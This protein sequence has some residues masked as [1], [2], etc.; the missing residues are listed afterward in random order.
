MESLPRNFLAFVAAAAGLVLSQVATTQPA[1]SQSATTPTKAFP[2]R[3]KIE[4]VDP[5]SDEFK[6]T[7]ALLKEVRGLEG[8]QE[9]LSPIVLP[10]DLTLRAKE[11]GMVNAWYNREDGKP[12]VTICYD[13]VADYIKKLPKDSTPEGITRQ[14]AAAGQF[15]WLVT[16]ESG[17]AMFDIFRMPIMGHEENAAD[18]FATYMMLH[19]GK[20]RARRLIGGSAWSYHAYV[21]DDRSKRLTKM[22]TIGFASAHAQPE[23]RFYNQLCLAYGADPVTFADL[24]KDDWLPESRAKTCRDDFQTL[25]FA[26][27]TLITPHVD[28]DLAKPIHD[29][30]W[31]PVNTSAPQ[32]TKAAT[33]AAKP[34]K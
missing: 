23:E 4:Y 12:V 8:M 11:C 1:L 29:I 18:N 21:S 26:M 6:A 32:V 25:A 16:H 22:Y 14:D 13:M 2:N 34:A 17:H 24:V 20:E 19:F 30:S 31:I 9:I 10:E 27:R 28:Q 33:E 3:V 5:K 7:A 15:F